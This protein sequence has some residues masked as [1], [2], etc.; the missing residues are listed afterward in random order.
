MRYATRLLNHGPV[1]LLTTADGDGPNVCA[2]A[3]CMPW[4]K[5]PPHF[6]MKLGR[7]HLSWDKLMATGEAV[8]NVPAADQ[9]A[10]VLCA[11][12]TEGRDLPPGTDKLAACGFEALPSR[13]VR[14]PRLA[15]C[16]AWLECRLVRRDLAEQ[17]GI[18][19]LEAVAAESPYLDERGTL[20]VLARPT[21]HHLGGD[22]FVADG[23]IIDLGGGD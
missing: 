6:V 17:E 5:K 2:V 8:L 10:A 22:R 7:R 18:V 3:W 13:V 11:G 16:V 23:R 15:G 9:A 19:F 14:P 20:D 4:S 12:R 1:T 21:L